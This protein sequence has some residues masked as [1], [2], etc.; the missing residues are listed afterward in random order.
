M[1]KKF[2]LLLQGGTLADGVREEQADIGLLNGKIAAKGNLSASD[3]ERVMDVKGLHIIPGVID[4]QVHFR[5]PGD[6]GAEDLA[7]GSKAALLGGVSAVFEMPNTTPSTTT[8]ASLEDKLNRAGGRMFCDYAFYVGGVAENALALPALQQQ[9]GCCGVKVFM[10]SSTGNLLAADDASLRKIMKNL[11]RVA[12]FHSEDEARLIER[13]GEAL[14]G[15]VET[16]PVWR[17]E[18]SA[19]RATKRLLKIAEEFDKQIHVLHVSTAEEIE[20]LAKHK[21]RATVEVTPQH[22]TLA[23]PECYERLGTLAQMNPPLRAARHREAL[24]QGITDGVVDIIGS[25]HAPHTLEAKAK[26]YPSSPSGMTGTQPLLPL[27]LNFVAQKKLTLARL[28]ELVCLNPVRRFGINKRQGLEIGS[29]A[30]LTIIDLY[31]TKTIHNNWIASKCGWTPF[32]GMKVRGFPQ[33]VVL[34]G[35]LAMWDAEIL[36]TAAGK[37]LDF[38]L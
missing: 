11:S 5:E 32:D 36:D 37:P 29:E 31:A 19:L 33:G 12:A 1:T 10:G 18:E 22:L 25:D 15:K 38:R 21:D 30:S 6:N 17:D 23:A 28:I 4:S 26:P 8:Q 24:W 2:N 14:A 3:A 9:S 13:Q 34:G 7:S 27:M 16:H 35:R 20:L